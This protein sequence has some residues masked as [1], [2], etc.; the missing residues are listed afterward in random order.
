MPDV[1]KA[2]IQHAQSQLRHALPSSGASWTRVAQF[3]LT[4]RFLGDVDAA[5]VGELTGA[6]RAACAG[7]GSM[8]LRAE[9]LGF[10]PNARRPRVLWVGIRDVANRLPQLQQLIERVATGF[11][12]A[13]DEKKFAEHVTLARLKQLQHGE[14]EVLVASVARMAANVFGEWE[15]DAVELMRSELRPDGARHSVVTSLPLAGAD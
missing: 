13:A 2:E 14:A 9:T 11:S 15:A 6:V 4:L 3:H 12:T 1:V 8:K 10:F 7:F 5:R